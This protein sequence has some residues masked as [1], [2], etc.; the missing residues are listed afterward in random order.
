MRI[1]GVRLHELHIPFVL[2]FT[3]GMASR[4]ACDSIIVEARTD[5]GKGFGEAIVRDYVS[6]ELS[7]GTGEGATPGGST[8]LAAAAAAVRKLASPLIGIDSSWADIRAFLEQAQADA[9]ELPIL[10]G[11][12]GAVL[13]CMCRET[14]ND[15]Y[16]LLEMLPS[17]EMRYGGT[18]PILPEK[19][20]KRFLG[21]FK[22]FRLSNARVKLGRDPAYA[23][24]ILGMARAAFGNEFDL[25]VDANACWSFEDAMAHLPLLRKHG[26]ILIEEP[27]GRGREENLRFKDEP[28]ARGFRLAADESALTVQDVEEMA[29]DG[30]FDMVNV[31]L[32]KNGGLLR[33]LRMARTARDGGLK[34]QIGCHVG[35]T[36][37]LSAIGRVAVSLCPDA[38]YADGSYDS[39]ILSDNITTQNYTFAAGGLAKIVRG[40]RMGHEVDEKKLEEYGNGKCECF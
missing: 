24:M 35:E 12:E 16:D 1:I 20:A 23:D 6:G 5:T 31:R 13:D 27:F 7:G 3:H 39:F 10:C 4:S 32:A 38:V 18:L 36:G 28:R 11:L 19:A 26:I 8:R 30:T 17:P 29:R 34:F 2:E 40:R 25:R 33:A 15:V 21:L 37:I 22:S 14:G 9:N